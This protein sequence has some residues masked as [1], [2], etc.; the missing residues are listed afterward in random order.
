MLNSDRAEIS[1]C[2]KLFKGINVKVNYEE[3]QRTG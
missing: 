3:L 1:D 2:I